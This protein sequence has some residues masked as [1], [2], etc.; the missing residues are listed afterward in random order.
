MKR[1]E[2]AGFRAGLRTVVLLVVVLAT[3]GGLAVWKGKSAE[4]AA[5][6]AANQP[7]PAEVVTEA[8][9]TAREHRAATTAIGTVLATRSVSL[10]NEV[11]GTVREVRLGPGRVVEAGELLV[12]L[13]VSVEEAELRALEA[14][15]E[16]AR[17]TLVRYER[18][19]EQQAAS[20]IERDN[21]RAER[22]IADAEIARVRAIIDRKTIRAPFRARV[23]LADVHPGQFLDVGTHL[24]TLQGVDDA[25][26]VDFQVSQAV[27]ASLGAGDVVEVVAGDDGVGLIEAHITA[28]DARV[29]PATRNATVRVRVA[30]ADSVALTPGASVRVRVPVGT[31]RVAV[32]VPASALRRGPS[33]DHVFVIENAD[34][35]Q[36][37]AHVRQITPGPVVGDDVLVFDGLE[38]GERVAASG[39]FKLRDGALVSIGEPAAGERAAAAAA[40]GEQEG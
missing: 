18:M 39:S 37:R 26:H 15:A 14:R 11:S 31:T 24:S 1:V 19:V 17:T 33:G 6:A 25:V 36:M 40:P 23:G 38:A 20:A 5:A 9:A 8:R 3:G 13:D 10:R 30:N 27:A 28:V 32:A 2:A 7:E 35:G 29:D 22:D 16:L 12:A 4:A 34:G 21:A